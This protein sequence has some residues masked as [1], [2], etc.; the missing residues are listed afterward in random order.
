ML[1][2][3]NG[4]SSLTLPI[5]HTNAA[6]V[7]HAPEPYSR[8]A[9]HDGAVLNPLT[10]TPCTRRTALRLAGFVA[11][12]TVGAT[13]L[14]GCGTGGGTPTPETPDPLVAQAERAR[15][16][17]ALA[18][19]ATATLPDLAGA[20]G[21]IAAERTAHADT[22]NAEIDRMNP[23]ASTSSTPAPTPAPVNPPLLVELKARLAESATGA[24]AV[25][26]TL[27]G[28]RAGLLGSISAACAVHTEVLLR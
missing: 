11:A 23:T 20:L 13:G 6:A 21:V 12:G 3:S 9:W 22:L 27:S 8:V 28:Y 7:S 10:A 25:S 2:L 24:A 18:T 14:A 5:R 19:A 17:A 26:R 15:S 4:L 1:S 16:D